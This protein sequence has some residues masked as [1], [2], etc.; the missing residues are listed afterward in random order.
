MTS[1]TYLLGYASAAKTT[2][3]VET[4]SAAESASIVPRTLNGSDLILGMGI[5]F[6]ESI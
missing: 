4:A 2:V 6:L 3:A 1:R 5:S